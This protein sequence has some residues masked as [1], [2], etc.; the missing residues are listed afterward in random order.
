M[1]L[2]T[3]DW[4][5]ISLNFAQLRLLTVFISIDQCSSRKQLS[6]YPTFQAGLPIFHNLFFQWIKYFS[7][8]INLS[9]VLYTLNH[10]H[11]VISFVPFSFLLISNLDVHLHGLN[12]IRAFLQ[13]GWRLGGSHNG[14]MTWFCNFICYIYQLLT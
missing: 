1:H 8:L 10:F 7:S 4:T 5:K 6:K 12:R 3:E 11:F 2:K 14:Q 13:G 9:Q